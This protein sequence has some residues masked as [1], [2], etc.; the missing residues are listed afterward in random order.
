[1][2]SSDGLVELWW[3]DL[4]Y[5][6]FTCDHFTDKPELLYVPLPEVCVQLA[7][8]S[9]GGGH[10][11]APRCQGERRQTALLTDPCP[12]LAKRADGDHVDHWTL[13][14]AVGTWWRHEYDAHFTEIWDKTYT[15]SSM[16][17]KVPTT[18]TRLLEHPSN[19][20]VHA[21]SADMRAR[22]V[23]EH[24]FFLM[25]HSLT[26]PSS[27]ALPSS[28]PSSSVPGR[29]HRRFHGMIFQF[30]MVRPSCLLAAAILYA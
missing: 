27:G 8:R 18:H 28:S 3:V 19:P 24:E 5:G 1:M 6:L 10:C 17:R 7:V 23:L 13:D 22:K 9:R 21:F 16:E 20:E 14:D 26:R 11:Q 25:I 4:S 2:G 15:T 29:F 12:W 30:R